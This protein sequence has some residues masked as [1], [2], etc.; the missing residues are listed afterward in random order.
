VTLAA[1]RIE[2]AHRKR[3]L[4]PSQT[5]GS[6][7]IEIHVVSELAQLLAHFCG[8]PCESECLAVH[9]KYIG[10]IGMFHMFH[11]ELRWLVDAV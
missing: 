10:Y 7:G 8:G 2:N 5:R 6:H 3:A 11:Q 1:A 9:Q 4:S